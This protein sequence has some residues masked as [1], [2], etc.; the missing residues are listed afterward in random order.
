MTAWFLFYA[1]LQY[2]FIGK[3]QIFVNTIGGKMLVIS[4]HT[5]DTV[6]K[7]KELIQE[8]EGIPLDQQLLYIA[9]TGKRLLKEELT[10][11]DFG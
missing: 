11:G 1:F 10:I 7:L 8:K 2:V 3:I 4:L 6:Q 5:K 9:G